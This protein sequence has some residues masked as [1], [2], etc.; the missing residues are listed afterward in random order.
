MIDK[1]EIRCIQTL[2]KGPFFQEFLVYFDYENQSPKKLQLRAMTK[3]LIVQNKVDEEMVMHE[4][5]IRSHIRHPFLINQICA[6]QD[7]D[8]LFYIA[9]YAPLK[10][11]KNSLLP[12]K[13]RIDVIK[14][15]AAEI[16]SCLRYLHSKNQVYTFVSP[17]NLMLA[18]DGHI[19]LDYAFCNCLNET[20]CDVLENIEYASLN[21]LTTNDFSM[22]GDYWSLGIIL[23]QM[24]LGYTPFGS[25]TFDETLQAMQV[26]EIE[27][28]DFIDA[29]LKD[30]ISLLLNVNRSPGW[31]SSFEDTEI[32]V[33]HPFFYD[34]DWC[35]L[36]NRELEPPY[37]PGVVYPGTDVHNAP[38]LGTLYT[39]DFIVGDKDG[40]GQTFTDY[41][42]VNFF[43]K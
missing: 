11:L 22:A 3:R 38:L 14:F 6:F 30:L 5:Y 23:Y 26:F 28:P 19:K 4:L 15:Y 41:N 12:R 9:E 16:L 36:E 17:D 8:N 35:R 31:L 33:N 25:E 37:I 21:Y 1:K 27:F 29:S 2:K 18:D 10:L 39:S 34:I 42:T 32:L 20:E 24:A 43:K 13:F 7:Y 40:Y